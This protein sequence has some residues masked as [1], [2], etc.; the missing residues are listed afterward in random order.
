MSFGQYFRPIRF[1]ILV[2][3]APVSIPDYFKPDTVYGD[4]IREHE[5]YVFLSV[6]IFMHVNLLFINP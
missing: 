4:K 2:Y 5:R 1:R 3:S 6:I